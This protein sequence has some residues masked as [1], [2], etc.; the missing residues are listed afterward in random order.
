LRYLDVACDKIFNEIA[1]QFKQDDRPT[2]I[3]LSSLEEWTIKHQ[4]HLHSVPPSKYTLHELSKFH[5]D[6]IPEVT[7]EENG[8]VAFLRAEDF[9]DM[10]LPSV[11]DI[12]DLDVGNRGLGESYW[13]RETVDSL[14][15]MASKCNAFLH[16]GRWVE[17]KQ[18]LPMVSTT[19]FSALD[20]SA[21]KNEEALDKHQV[22]SYMSHYIDFDGGEG[23]VF[24]NEDKAAMNLVP[25]EETMTQGT[26]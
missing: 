4:Y 26:V 18:G 13:K 16:P 11:P 12:D 21:A 9:D 22:E 7:W 20:S 1:S 15:N 3:R 8:D 17:L 6:S 2:D 5:T 23:V 25:D 10:P 24:N 14:R 19:N